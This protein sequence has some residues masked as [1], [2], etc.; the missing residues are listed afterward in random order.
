MKYDVSIAGDIPLDEAS[1]LA[2]ELL[3][4]AQKGIRLTFFKRVL[5]PE[6]C[7]FQEKITAIVSPPA[8]LSILRQFKLPSS[9]NRVVFA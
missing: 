9:Y 4:H 3:D 1:R 6:R 7:K 8:T 5:K 2:K